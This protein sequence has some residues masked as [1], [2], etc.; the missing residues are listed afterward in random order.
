M[1][2][3]RPTKYEEHFPALLEVV[4]EEKHFAVAFCKQIGISEDTFYRWVKIHSDF[5]ES[6]RKARTSCK[7]NF[8]E[9][10]TNAAFDPEQHKANNGLVTLLAVN[11]YG[12]KT[13]DDGNKN[14]D[15]E[16][17]EPIKIEI[18]RK[19]GKKKSSNSK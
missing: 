11:C 13:R 7:A 2:T 19:S 5:S 1:R 8:L 4:M 12:M 9:K 3:G 17:P 15:E 16:D 14:D 6:Y 18:V 10:V